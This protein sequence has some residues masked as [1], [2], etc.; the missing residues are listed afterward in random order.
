M[1]YRQALPQ[2]T[3]QHSKVLECLHATNTVCMLCA[4]RLAE[5]MVRYPATRTWLLKIDD[6]HMGNGHAYFR[7]QDINGANEVLDRYDMLG[8][9]P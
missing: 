6:E 7:R 9:V 3:S 5:A 2:S 8:K 4:L 1:W